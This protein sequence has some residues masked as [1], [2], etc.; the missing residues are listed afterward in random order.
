[1][2]ISAKSGRVVG[3]LLGGVVA[4]TGCTAAAPAPQPEPAVVTETPK[5][6]AGDS[7]TA[8]P[9][10]IASK[11]DTLVLP[12]N[13]PELGEIIFA[14]AVTDTFE[15]IDPG[16]FF[17]AGFTQIHAVFTYR[18]MSPQDTWERVWTVNDH[19]VARRADAWTEPAEGIFDYTID[20]GGQPLPPG[21]YVLA[22]YVNGKL[23]SLGAFI[24]E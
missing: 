3:L 1:M 12:E 21:D 17:S 13:Q 2:P 22:I 23:Q 19:E 20:N 15:P 11:F 4:V 14:P 10:Q 6:S 16:I 18:D 5:A 9:Q 24:I 8:A 7:L